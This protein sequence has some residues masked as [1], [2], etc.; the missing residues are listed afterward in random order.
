[1][2]IGHFEVVDVPVVYYYCVAA[3]YSSQNENSRCSGEAMM[4]P[5]NSDID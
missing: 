3:A 2:C 1:M 5:H 4:L